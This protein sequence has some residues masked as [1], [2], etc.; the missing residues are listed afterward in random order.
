MA[1]GLQM[2]I[3]GDVAAWRAAPETE[4]GREHREARGHTVEQ[5]YPGMLE[6]IG[7]DDDQIK[8]RGQMVNLVSAECAVLG[9]AALL[10]S[11]ALIHPALGR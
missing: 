4:A 9:G 8:I 1:A 2:F 6:V 11:I 7:R 5:G 3:S 10:N